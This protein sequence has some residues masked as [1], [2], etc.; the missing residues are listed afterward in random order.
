MV[1]CPHPFFPVGLSCAYTQAR[2]DGTGPWSAGPWAKGT[3]SAP[4][5]MPCW[6]WPPCPMA[7]FWMT[8]TPPTT[9]HSECRGLCIHPRTLQGNGSPL[10]RWSGPRESRRMVIAQQVPRGLRH[11][12]GKPA[13]HMEADGMEAVETPSGELGPALRV[14]RLQG[15]AT[16]PSSLGP[17]RPWG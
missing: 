10:V 14:A 5:R 4:A 17:R 8:D 3:G 12:V 6:Q 7:E 2:P 1:N 13:L 16:E 15:C 9:S 11:P